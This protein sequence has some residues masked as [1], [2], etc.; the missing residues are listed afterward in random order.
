MALTCGNATHRPV[1]RPSGRAG[2]PRSRRYVANRR[3][4]APPAGPAVNEVLLPPCK[5]TARRLGLQNA[6]PAAKTVEG[7][8]YEGRKPQRVFRQVVV[9]MLGHSIEDLWTEVPEG[10]TPDFV[11]LKGTSR[12]HPMP[13][14]AWT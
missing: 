13:T 3:S 9:E 2:S 1:G 8:F 5:E 11:P 10:T 4:P 12:P 6:D 14:P 7:W